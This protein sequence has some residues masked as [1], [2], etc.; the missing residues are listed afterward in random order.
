MTIMLV[1]AKRTE[2]ENP[3]AIFHLQPLSRGISLNNE[4]NHTK[5]KRYPTE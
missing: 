1:M 3:L 5:T 4:R 2:T